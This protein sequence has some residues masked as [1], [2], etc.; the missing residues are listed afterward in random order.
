VFRP[1]DALETAEC[2]ELALRRQDGPCLLVLSRQELPS[3][4]GDAGE[5]RCS[6]GAYVLAEADGPRQA[7][8]IASG[9]EVAVAMGARDALSQE[10][11]NVAVVSLPSWE[12]FAAQGSAYRDQVLGAVPRIGIEAA[13]GFGWD[14][15]LGPNG[16]FIGL[17]G[18][19]TSANYMDLY[20]FFGITPETVVAAVK[21]KLG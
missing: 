19:G 9:S 17:Q 21:S 5:N 14:Q 13:T 20:R 8:L 12:L 10:G 2:W 3:W 6:R 11:I 15:W 16:T 7:T 1:A 4:R 18:F